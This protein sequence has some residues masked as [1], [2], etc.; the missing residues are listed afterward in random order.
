MIRH[1][2]IVEM[3]SKKMLI[4]RLNENIQN[5]R[6]RT[7]NIKNVSN[8]HCTLYI[9]NFL[10]FKNVEISMQVSNRQLFHHNDI[11]STNYFWDITDILQAYCGINLH[12]CNISAMLYCNLQYCN[13]ATILLQSSELYGY[14]NVNKRSNFVTKNHYYVTK[15]NLFWLLCY[16][17][18]II[19]IIC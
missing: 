4:R 11:F 6:L 16:Q 10:S 8:S 12:F 2:A 17:N 14:N 9:H 1:I 13:I 3:K 15:K 5:L 18:K 19:K 7:K